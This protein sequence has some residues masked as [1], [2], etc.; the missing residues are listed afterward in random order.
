MRL[1]KTKY[2]QEASKYLNWSIYLHIAAIGNAI[3]EKIFYF[4]VWLKMKRAEQGDQIR[5]AMWKQ[6][7]Q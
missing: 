3:F 2:I 7:L 4:Y 1:N 6:M 5:S